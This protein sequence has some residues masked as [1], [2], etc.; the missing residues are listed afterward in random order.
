MYDLISIGTVAVDLYF[1]GES[2]TVEDNRFQ[3]AIGGKYFADG[4][5]EGLGGGATNVAIGAK[6]SGIK[7]ALAATIGE[8]VFKK[9]IIHKLDE[10]KIN[11]SLSIFEQDYYNISAVLVAPSGDRS[12][13]NYRSPHQETYD[14][15]DELERLVNTKM[16]YLANL[17][18]LSLQK[19]TR[20]LHFFKDRGITTFANLGVSDCRKEIASLHTFLKQVDVLIINAHEFAEIVRKDYAKIDLT[21]NVLKTYLPE[22]NDLTLILTDGLKGSYGYTIDS[23][24]HQKAIKAEKVV[25]ATGAGDG[26]TAGFIAAY[27][28]EPDI[29]KAMQAGAEYSTKIVGVVGAN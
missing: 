21:T 14:Q 24:I 28:K 11:Y 2:L 23:V 5:Y 27:S 4:F 10:L 8:N 13:V 20:M 29:K 17:P 26:Y 9:V 19:K 18:S 7:V 16:V 3:L 15:K 25:D 6:K 1:K 12:I 22:L